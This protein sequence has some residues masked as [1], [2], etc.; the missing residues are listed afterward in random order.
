MKYLSLLNRKYV[1]YT[2]LNDAFLSRL[3]GVLVLI[4]GDQ[5]PKKINF[6]HQIIGM[7]CWKLLESQA[8]CILDKY[9]RV[10]VRP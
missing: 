5:I 3:V 4:L 8:L 10:Y 1:L 2:V 9:S 7:A 6:I